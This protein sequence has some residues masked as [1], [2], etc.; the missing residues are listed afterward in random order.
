MSKY[1]ASRRSAVQ[2][3]SAAP[4]ESIARE[5]PD[6]VAVG[7]SFDGRPHTVLMATPADL[8]DL[9]VGFTITEAVAAQA[10][11]LDVEVRETELGWLADVRLRPGAIQRKARPRTLEGR[12]SC[13]LCGVQ[14][15][16]DAV[17][18]LPTVGQGA[19]VS[20]Q[21]IQRA[22]DALDDAQ[23]LG[24]LTRA[25]HAAAFATADGALVLVREDVG[26]HNA[27]DKLAGAMA[28]ADA[29]APAFDAQAGF[30]LVTSRCSF[31]MVEKTARMGCSMLVAVS[32][33]TDLAIQRAETAGVTLVA[34]ARSDGHTV[35]TRADRLFDA[36]SEY[37]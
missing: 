22:V 36:V 30:V 19:R 31:E 21:A 29:D 7:L 37:A 12:S 1:P 15:L 16:A 10:D 32:A 14:R 28:G 24:R 13:G 5:T 33:P 3:R 11:I 26:R 34:L 18:P 25:T 9:A 35:F 6:E 17:R 20:H 8:R 4:L 23:A 2:W 27:L